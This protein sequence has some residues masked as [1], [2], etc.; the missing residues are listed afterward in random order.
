MM[1]ETSRRKQRSFWVELPILLLV[2][3]I[4]AVLVR[5]FLVQTFYIPSGSMETTLLINDR[6]LV[7]KMVYRF[8]EPRRGEVVVFVPPKQWDAGPS[9]DDYIKRVVAVGGDKVV[10][11]DA[12]GKITINGRPLNEDYLYE[13]DVPSSQ[14]FDVTVPTGRLFV[15]GDHRSASADSRF[16]PDYQSGTIP[17]DAVVGRAF[18]I[19]WPF[20]HMATLP[21]PKGYE[22]IP[23]PSG[24]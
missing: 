13:D 20:G 7:N 24:G 12:S 1:P 2:A 3:V 15:L 18:V 4:V 10:C 14:P 22:A 9:K 5:T 23:A 8:R 21:V 19:F 11:C 16:H 6:V 17:V